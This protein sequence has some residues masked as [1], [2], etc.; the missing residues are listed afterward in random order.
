MSHILVTGA[1][2]FIGSHLVRHLLALKQRENW[3]EEIVCLV[4]STSGLSSLKGLDVKL[5]IGDVRDPE[6]LVKAVEGATYIFHL[7]ADL[8]DISRKRFLETNTEG[9]E[10]L[11]KAA[12]KH[13]KESLKRFLFVSSQAAAGPAPNEVPITEE[14]TPPPPVSWYAESKLEAERIAMRYAS[15]FPVTV[16]RPCSVYGERD[17]AFAM[18]F[19]AAEL[20]IQAVAGFKKS[21]TGMIYAPDLVEGM[22][23]AARHPETAGQIYFLANPE[24]YSVAEAVKT[25]GKA[26][27]KP[28]GLKV[29]VPI[30]LFRI[31][32]MISEFLYLFTRKKPIPS[33]DKVRDISQVYWLCTPKKAQEHFG[34]QAKTTLLEGM[35]ATHDYYRKERQKLSQMP[36]ES[37]D[38]LW[39]KYF[40][41]SLGIGILIEALAAFGKVYAF[42]PWWMVFGILL[43]LW[44]IVFGSIA[45]AT[46]TRGFLVQYLPGFAL[47][48]GGELL[49]NYYLHKWEFYNDALYGITNPVLRA[50]VLGIATGFL[51]PIINQIMIQFYKIKLRLG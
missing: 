1:N 15:D 20:G 49:N 31:M 51:I 17:P 23:A 11:L 16:V 2:G 41:L 38:I 18:A 3:K 46:R 34:W 14:S 36:D 47:L 42:Q 30:F 7:A 4:R 32:A 26:A 40:S 43:G 28:S 22:V 37:K 24:N 8:Y 29:R 5:V 25:M 48:F 9:T 12:G 39:L 6:T 45:M 21:Y 13:A 33:R 35:R 27:G 50:A 19:Q 10:N 44:G